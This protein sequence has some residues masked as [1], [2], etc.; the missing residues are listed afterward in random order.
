[1]IDRSLGSAT[2]I[3][4]LPLPRARPP[5]IS[6]SRHRAQRENFAHLDIDFITKIVQTWLVVTMDERD[7]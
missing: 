4:V 2:L 3:S 5:G 6:K 7:L 1:M